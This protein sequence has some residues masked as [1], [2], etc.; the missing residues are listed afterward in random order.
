[1][2]VESRIPRRQP[3][4]GEAELRYLKDYLERLLEK[5]VARAPTRREAG[6][7]LWLR[8]GMD[9]LREE[10]AG[11]LTLERPVVRSSNGRTPTEYQLR[12]GD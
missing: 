6:F 2:T 4:Y 9:W 10:H 8:D 7:R 5:T 12:L 11:N 3:H 1:M